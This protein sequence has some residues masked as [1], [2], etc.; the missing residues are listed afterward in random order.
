MQNHAYNREEAAEQQKSTL[1]G[2]TIDADLR[3]P[4]TSFAVASG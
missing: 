1:Q 4:G 3:D 2:Q